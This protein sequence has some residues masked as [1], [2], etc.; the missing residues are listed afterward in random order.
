MF[1]LHFVGPIRVS[2]YLFFVCIVFAYRLVYIYFGNAIFVMFR[3]E[4]KSGA[5]WYL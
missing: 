5:N 4:K 1:V 3:E 2:V